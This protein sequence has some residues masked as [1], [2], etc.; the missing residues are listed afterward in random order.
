MNL[1]HIPISAA[2]PFM[3]KYAIHKRHCTKKTIIELEKLGTI[4]N[5]FENINGWDEIHKH[6]GKRANCGS[7]I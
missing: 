3:V 4:I 6:A 5:A 7:G 1:W 2:S